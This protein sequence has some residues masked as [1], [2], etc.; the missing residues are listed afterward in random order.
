MI[1]RVEDYSRGFTAA[2]AKLPY[3]AWAN[4][5]WRCGWIKGTAARVETEIQVA[6]VMKQFM[7][8]RDKETGL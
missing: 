6:L 4:E 3:N 8:R 2:F 5:D 7:A 1:T